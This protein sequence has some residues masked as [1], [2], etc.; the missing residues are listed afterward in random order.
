MK[1]EE[2]RQISI[3]SISD[4]GL[5]IANNFLARVKESASE[6]GVS[7]WVDAS[8]LDLV[9]ASDACKMLKLL[10]YYVKSHNE[11]LEISWLP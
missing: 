4:S 1:A 2:A 3:L 7:I 5:N 9:A 11:M 6:S 10:G 8:G